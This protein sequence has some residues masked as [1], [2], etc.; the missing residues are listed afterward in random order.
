MVLP[1]A[2]FTRHTRAVCSSR[3]PQQVCVGWCICCSCGGEDILSC[4]GHSLL[5]LP[6][7][8]ELMGDAIGGVILFLYPI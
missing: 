8:F 7:A 2:A 6:H 4:Q 3:R 5:A 1:G